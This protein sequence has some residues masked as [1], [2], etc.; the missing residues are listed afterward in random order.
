MKSFLTFK[1]VNTKI[2]LYFQNVLT[3]KLWQ[4]TQ[5]KTAIF[6]YFILTAKHGDYSATVRNSEPI[7]LL[8]SPRSLS[9]S[10]LTR[11]YSY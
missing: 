7:K 2:F 4:N 8:E 11:Y 10:I 9:V 3:L 1:I 6:F 5:L